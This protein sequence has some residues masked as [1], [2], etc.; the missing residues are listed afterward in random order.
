M[1]DA[2]ANVSL[3]ALLVS[4][5]STEWASR[6]AFEPSNFYV[7]CYR[8]FCCAATITSYITSLLIF[9]LLSMCALEGSSKP[10]KSFPETRHANKVRKIQA[11]TKFP[12]MFLEWTHVSIFPTSSTKKKLYVSPH[13]R[14]HI[15]KARQI[16]NAKIKARFS[17]F[18][19]SNKRRERVKQ[20]Q[21]HK[22]SF[23]LL[24]LIIQL[25]RRRNRRRNRQKQNYNEDRD[26]L[27]GCL[28]V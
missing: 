12:L 4:Q 19:V 10:F 20:S 28:F 24:S 13:P 21:K 22:S 26:V 17:C 5:C 25:R 8:D 2:H 1:K 9:V 23:K 11:N 7:T 14:V 15:S 18:K 27:E 6:L 16:A 3:F